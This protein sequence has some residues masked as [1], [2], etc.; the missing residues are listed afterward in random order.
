[1]TR[2]DVLTGIAV[3]KAGFPHST[4]PSETI[5]LYVSRLID[6]RVEPFTQAVKDIIDEENYF[7]TI[8]TLV[9]TYRIHREREI[10]EDERFRLASMPALE[11][12]PPTQILHS[13]VEEYRQTLGPVSAKEDAVTSFVA[14]LSRDTPGLCDDCREYVREDR[15]LYGKF[16]LCHGDVTRRVRYRLATEAA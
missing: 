3:L 6:Y 5:E 10:A 12:E 15:Y 1:M 8:H 14:G 7:P 11:F 4:V 2:D 16:S 9:E 13:I